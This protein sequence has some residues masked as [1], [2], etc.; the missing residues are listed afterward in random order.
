[1]L[2]RI[3]PT[4]PRVHLLAHE[5]NESGEQKYSKNEFTSTETKKTKDYR[6]YVSFLERGLVSLTHNDRAR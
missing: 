4:Q 5:E 6:H 1:M 3:M 2:K